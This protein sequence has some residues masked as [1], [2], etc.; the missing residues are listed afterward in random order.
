MA[1]ILKSGLKLGK[2]HRLLWPTQIGVRLKNASWWGDEFV[3][4][5]RPDETR[6]KKFGIKLPK[7]GQMVWVYNPKLDVTPAS[8]GMYVGTIYTNGTVKECVLMLE[9]NK[10]D[11]RRMMFTAAPD[12]LIP[13]TQAMI[14]DAKKY[15]FQRK[16]LRRL[17][18]I[19]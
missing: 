11:G 9:T 17:K 12:R 10:R 16:V 2:G 4:Y 6:R 15:A 1:E 7:P 19:K 5:G 13:I 18:V 14:R 8:I 3:G